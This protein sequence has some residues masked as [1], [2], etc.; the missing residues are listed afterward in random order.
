MQKCGYSEYS[1]NKHQQRED[2]CSEYR[3]SEYGCRS[4]DTVS[5]VVISINNERMVAVST[6]TVSMVAEV[7][8]Q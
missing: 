3:H 4:A 2:G 8:I 7:R 6:G 5:T 1:C